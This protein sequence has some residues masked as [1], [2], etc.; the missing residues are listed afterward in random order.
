MTVL[1]GCLATVLPLAFAVWMTA[2]PRN[3]WRTLAS[4]RHKDPPANEPSGAAFALL[5]LVGATIVVTMVVAG[6]MLAD[7]V[8]GADDDGRAAYQDCVEMHQPLTEAPAVS[9]APG[10]TAQ[11][12]VDP[13]AEEQCADLSPTPGS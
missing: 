13:P 5:R 9:P 7:A 11:P 1:C 12:G 3:M 6:I 8:A 10:Q 2:A 4:W